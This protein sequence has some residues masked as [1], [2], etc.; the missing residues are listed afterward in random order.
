MRT[1]SVFLFVAFFA[2]A[3]MQLRGSTQVALVDPAPAADH[4]S[5]A[6][7]CFMTAKLWFDTMLGP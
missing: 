7:P 3:E 5:G 1:L 6:Y 2:V 4:T